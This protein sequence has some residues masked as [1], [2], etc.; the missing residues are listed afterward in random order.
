MKVP[1]V[2]YKEEL[3]DGAVLKKATESAL[4]MIGV[5]GLRILYYD[6]EVRGILPEPGKMC[7]L[8]EVWSA[9]NEI[10]GRESGTMMMDR[11]YQQLC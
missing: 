4:G 10:F 7:S 8:K 1:K 3:V 5:K 2:D 9:L 11:L 6:F